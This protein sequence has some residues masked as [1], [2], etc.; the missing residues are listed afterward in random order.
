MDGLPSIQRDA[1]TNAK[2]EYIGYQPENRLG[3]TSLGRPVVF[4]GSISETFHMS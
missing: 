1:V 3:K 4:I 2:V